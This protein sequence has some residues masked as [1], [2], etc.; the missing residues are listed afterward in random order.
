MNGIMT[1]SPSTLRLGTRGSKLARAQAET[2]RAALAEALID[3]AAWI[4]LLRT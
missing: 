2:V 4:E 1:H 3:F